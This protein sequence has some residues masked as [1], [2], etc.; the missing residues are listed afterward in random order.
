MLFRSNVA[1]LGADLVVEH[2]VGS[3]ANPLPGYISATSAGNQI[4]L[5]MLG[6]AA[7]NAELAELM[8]TRNPRISLR[9]SDANTPVEG[10]SAARTVNVT[11]NFTKNRTPSATLRSSGRIDVTNPA[12]AMNVTVT[13]KDT[14]ARIAD[15][16]LYDQQRAGNVIGVPSGEHV[17][18][19]FEARFTPGGNS[20]TI[21]AKEADHVNGRG[22]GH[23]VPGV[24]RNLSW[25]VILDNEADVNNPQQPLHSWSV[26]AKNGRVSDKPVVVNPVQGASRVVR[27]KSQVTLYRATPTHGEFIQLRLTAPAGAVYENIYVN[28]RGQAALTPGQRLG[29]LAGGFEAVRRGH[30]DWTIRFEDGRT[31]V[32]G[33]NGRF[34]NN[35]TISLEL[36]PEGTYRLHTAATTDNA[37]LYGTMM[38]D[39][40]GRPLP[41][42]NGSR[43]AT[44][45]AAVN[46]R[47]NVK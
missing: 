8:E 22:Y 2:M 15:V 11:L 31:P 21:V 29:F 12:A 13:F 44:K 30:D 47:V 34:R 35:Y 7:T 28:A 24:R 40:V 45:P 5:S 25:T 39:A 27:D 32:V 17:S 6:T 20:F 26:N 16:I 46:L 18:Q 4:S 33:G 1:N 42:L 19:D 23:I 41:L 9:I 10:V 3:V 36:W 37:A 38:R 14:S 43:A